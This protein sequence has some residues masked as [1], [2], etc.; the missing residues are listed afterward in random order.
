MKELVCNYAIARF[1]PYRET[2]EFVNI[3]VVLA[4]PQV[5]FFDYLFVK[6]KHKRVTDF[7]PELD[8]DIFKSALQSFLLEM[9]RLKTV[10]KNDALTQ[11]YLLGEAKNNQQQFRELVR[12]RETLLHF[13]EVGTILAQNPAAK[14][15]ELFEYYIKRQ[16]AQDREY[17]EIIMRNKLAEFLRENRL[18]EHYKPKQVGDDNYHVILPFVFEQQNKIR[19]AIKPLHLDKEGPTEIYRHGDYW[20]SCVR[21]LKNTNKLPPE[22][23]FA[24][25]APKAN[26]KCIAAAEDICK[27]LQELETTT[28]PFAE[29]NR[30]LDFANI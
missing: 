15:R 6:R 11:Y 2:G 17:Q 10:D 9:E 1:L 14:L 18:D 25:K 28:A 4:C 8:L 27:E 5:G 19:K 23:L 21:R 22:M 30:I 20:I 3:G 24:V 29:R 7:F 12:P 16:F 13:G 26:E